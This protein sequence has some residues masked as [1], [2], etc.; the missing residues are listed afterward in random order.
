MFCYTPRSTPGKTYV[1][2]SLPMNPV[3]TKPAVKPIAL[4]AMGGD[5]MPQA[6]VGGAKAAA[7]AGIPVVLVGDETVIRAELRAQDTDLPIH[8]AADVIRM[9]DHAAD[10]RR[11][12]NSSVMQAMRLV[13]DAQASA[14]VSVGHS[15]AT[16]ASALFVLGRLKG[17]ERPAI[18]AN[19]PTNRGFTALIDAGANA[20]CRPTHLQQFAVMGSVYARAFYGLEAPSVGLISLGEEPEKGNELTREAHRLLRDTPGVN[21]YGNVEGRDLLKGTTDVVVADG[22]TGNVMLKLA[23]GEAKVIFGWVREALSGGGLGTKLGAALVRPALRSIAARLDPSEYG[24]QPL[25][26]V[27]GYA[28]IGHGSSD[29]R[30][31]ENALRTAQRAVDAELVPKLMAGM[32]ALEAAKTSEAVTPAPQV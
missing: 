10:V 13:K 25:L 14:C 24:A 26:G 11:R 19:I 1:R 8:H 9:E 28:F 29:A 18:L 22:F 15:G 6:A 31:V 12:K 17:L 30:A 7:A 20:D 16:M 32:A 4:D 27:N 23:E 3:R 21:F 2:V 5:A